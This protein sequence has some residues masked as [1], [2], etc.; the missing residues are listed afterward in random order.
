MT[1][2][3]LVT[4]EL[5]SPSLRI[6][7]IWRDVLREPSPSP[8]KTVVTTQSPHSM[9]LPNTHTTLKSH[10]PYAGIC[11]H[12]RI[13]YVKE[14]LCRFF[15]ANPS[16]SIETMLPVTSS[17]TASLPVLQMPSSGLWLLCRKA[18]DE[19]GAC[20]CTEVPGKS[21][22]YYCRRIAMRN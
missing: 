13:H 22:C 3:N 6:T 8:M 2:T 19:S 20:L 7:G 12:L 5:L 1:Q 21:W 15:L 9:V 14:T 16:L 11:H 4:A 17:F 18:S 10:L